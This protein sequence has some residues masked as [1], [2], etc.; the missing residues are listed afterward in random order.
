[1]TPPIAFIVAPPVALPPKA[2]ALRMEPYDV[3][4]DDKLF[5][6]AVDSATAL[7]AD[8]LGLRQVRN[9]RN[10]RNGVD[11]IAVFGMGIR[12]TK[13]AI[14][15]ISV[16]RNVCRNR[17]AIDFTSFFRCCFACSL[18]SHLSAVEGA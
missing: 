11:I 13:A 3:P 15:N 8:A 1:L 18:V 7:D 17:I 10:I 2:L 9:I 5:L 16:M 14:R 6:G 12:N 4:V